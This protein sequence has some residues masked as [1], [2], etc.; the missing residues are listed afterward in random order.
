[1]T[2]ELEQIVTAA[3]LLG[4]IVF[5]LAYALLTVFMVPG[6]VTSVAGG[7]LFGPVWGT[8]LVLI[9]ASLGA[10]A[11]F[12]IARGAGRQR[13]KRRLGR[14]LTDFDERLTGSGF[15]SVLAVRL[16]PIAPFNLSNYAFGM[17]GVFP[18]DYVT[19]TVIGIVPGTIAFVA[20]GDSL[21]DPGSVGFFASIAAVLALLIVV[22]L[23]DRR[24][25]GRRQGAGRRSP[26]V[27]NPGSPDPAGPVPESTTGSG[28][29]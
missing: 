23:L 13:V 18:R 16:V 8:V 19:A 15:V 17:T 10:I 1:M 20:L 25:R 28:R 22:P 21:G 24:L 26:G 5:V 9:G 4:P 3:G 27:G 29:Q 12:A 14:R 7:A 11:A 6:S 2:H